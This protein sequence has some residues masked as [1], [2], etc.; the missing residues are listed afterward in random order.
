MVDSVELARRVSKMY[1]DLY[2]GTDKDNPS[3]TTRL[4]VTEN[5]V[6]Q[7]KSNLS[8]LVWLSLGILGTAIANIVLH[9]A[10]K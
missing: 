9:L 8:K 4:T 10:G 3:I 6:E 5:N 7:I 1:V 2:E